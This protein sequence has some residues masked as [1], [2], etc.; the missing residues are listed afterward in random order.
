MLP[1]K[2]Y[3]L[4]LPFAVFHIASSICFS[5]S[6]AIIG[7]GTMVNNNYTYPAPYGNYYWGSKH[8]ILVRAS[9]MTSAGMT[10][11]NITALAFQIGRAHV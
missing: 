11:G 1:M 7:T 4:L 9:E 5:Q 3:L 6:T 8:Q 10:A 2:K